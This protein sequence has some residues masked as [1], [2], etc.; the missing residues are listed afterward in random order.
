M[1]YGKWEP[2]RELGRGGQGTAYLAINT[3]RLDLNTLFDELRAAVGALGAIRTVEQNRED[4]RRVL[5]LVDTYL[6]RESNE[7]TG[8]LKV[9][10]ES[11]RG[12]PKALARLEQEVEILWKID[13]PHLIKVLDASVR[14]GWFVMPYYAAGSLDRHLDRFAGKPAETLE[15]FRGLVEGVT[16]LHKFGAVHRD[17]KPENI[18]L[19]PTGL[20][21]GDF[22]IVYF[23]DEAK[24]RIS[25]TYENVG[26]RD[27][28]PGWAM[29]MRVE[30]VRPSFDVFGLGKVLWAMVSGRTKLRLWYFRRDE[31]NLER[32]FPDDERMRWVN[33]LLEGAV[34][35]NEAEVWRSGEELLGQV[36]GISAILRRG[37]QIVNRDIPRICN[38]CGHGIL[39]TV[40]DETRGPEAFRNF[41]LDPAG[42]RFRIFA[43]D[44]C[45]NVQ[46]FRMTRNPP[47]WG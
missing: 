12:D 36:D 38:V 24:T 21:L 39:R 30:D 8:V 23:A 7:F 6:R 27:W 3:E 13:H 47:G 33:R 17:I 29:G 35:E 42:E 11:A 1:K 14:D 31:F 9:L 46:W 22:G 15:A 34:R 2:L 43:C 19:T 45:G 32:Q 4:A 26:S 5:R 10:H 37:G 20:V 40:V 41:G 28:M 18:F 44:N 16:V 25:D